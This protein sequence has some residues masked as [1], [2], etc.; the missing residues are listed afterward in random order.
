M[1]DRGE[2]ALA[3]RNVVISGAAGGIGAALARRFGRAGARLGLLDLDAAGVAALAG[4]LDADGVQALALRCDV[5]SLEDCRAAV[6]EVIGAW[7]GVDVL[8]ANAGITHVSFFRDTDVEVI[9]RVMEVNFFGAVNCTKAALDSLR[10]RRGHIVAISSV[11]GFAPLATRCGY[12]ASKHAMH[13][14]FDSLRGELRSEGV[15]VS[16]FC[17]FFVRTEIGKSALG[18][19]GG[20][21]RMPR[22]ETGTPAEPEEV[23]D[24]VLRAVLRNRRLVAFPGSARLAYLLSRFLPGLYERIMVRRIAP[25]PGS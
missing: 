6:A 4:E 1:A 20:S 12:S 10:E 17:P 13:G 23:A 22:T 5:T 2:L 11:A 19:D 14:F 3:G 18:G 21:P 24:A 25:G 8:V 7:S 15:G 9:R 16:V